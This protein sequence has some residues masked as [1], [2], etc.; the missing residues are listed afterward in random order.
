M[1]WLNALTLCIVLVYIIAVEI[2][3]GRYF[4]D[5]LVIQVEYIQL[6]RASYTAAAAATH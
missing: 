6:C 2:I 3:S 4:E 1:Y 5:K